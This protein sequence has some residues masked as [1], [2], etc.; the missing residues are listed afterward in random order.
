MYTVL[1]S[2]VFPGVQMQRLMEDYQYGRDY[3]SAEHI[4]DG[5]VTRDHVRRWKVLQE[6]QV[7]SNDSTACQQ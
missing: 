1:A 6:L 5:G 7:M 2:I 4:T 3:I